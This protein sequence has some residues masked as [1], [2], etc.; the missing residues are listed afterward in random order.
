MKTL[1]AA[2]SMFA[3]TA[4]PTLAC[5]ALKVGDTAPAFSAKASLGGKEFDFNLDAALKKGPVVLYFF[6]AAFTTGCTTEAHLFADASDAYAKDGATLIGVTA[7]HIDRIQEFSVS[8]CRNKFP[9]AADP[10]AVIAQSYKSKLPIGPG[11]SDRTSYVIGR[12]HKVAY[13]YSALSPDKHVA[14][15]LAAVKTM[16]RK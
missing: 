14:N 1:I 12:D 2:A 4:V 3:I 11:W 10:G 16:T 9:V 8:E 5:A 7:G 15:T 6:P 13:V